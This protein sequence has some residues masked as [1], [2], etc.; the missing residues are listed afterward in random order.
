MESLLEP[1][2]KGKWNRLREFYSDSDRTELKKDL[3]GLLQE[4]IQRSGWL[5]ED[6]GIKQLKRVLANKYVESVYACV[7][8][9]YRKHPNEHVPLVLFD[10]DDLI[11]GRASTSNK[12]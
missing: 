11:E 1:R 4:A 7:Q 6:V 5:P 12:N 9:H 3:H 10:L 8:E 2:T